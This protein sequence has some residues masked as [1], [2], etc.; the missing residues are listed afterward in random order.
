ME[1]FTIFSTF[2]AS[3]AIA[4]SVGCLSAT[5]YIGCR[6]VLVVANLAQP[7]VREALGFAALVGIFTGLSWFLFQLCLYLK[8]LEHQFLVSYT[9]IVVIFSPITLFMINQIENKRTAKKVMNR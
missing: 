4:V 3:L 8:L 7:P 9:I 1:A 2:L 6:I 5:V